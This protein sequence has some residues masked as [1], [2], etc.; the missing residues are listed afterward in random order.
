M[1]AGFTKSINSMLPHNQ[2]PVFR[3]PFGVL[4]LYMF[5]RNYTF[6]VFAITLLQMMLD[7]P[8][9]FNTLDRHGKKTNG[10]SI[11]WYMFI[12]VYFFCHAVDQRLSRSVV[13]LFRFARP[14]WV[15]CLKISWSF[16]LVF[17]IRVVCRIQI[18]QWSH[19]GRKRQKLRYRRLWEIREPLLLVRNMGGIVDTTNQF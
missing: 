2:Q 15:V 8:Q 7:I 16:V 13:V 14:F 4:N 17:H 1:Q 12:C 11:T 18:H 3:L 9:L 5:S 19:H 6:I 10:L